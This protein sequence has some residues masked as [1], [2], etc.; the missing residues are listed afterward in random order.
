MDWDG[1]TGFDLI[2]LEK[3]AL[4]FAAA[5]FRV[6]LGSKTAMVT[7]SHERSQDV[8]CPSSPCYAIV[9]LLGYCKGQ[10]SSENN[11]LFS[12]DCI[13]EFAADDACFS[14]K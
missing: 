6:G 10:K 14:D 12:F 9:I 1:H 3:G 4:K 5:V 2:L 13:Y 8:I 7:N 11:D